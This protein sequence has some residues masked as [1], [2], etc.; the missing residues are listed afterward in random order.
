MFQKIAIAVLVLMV[1]TVAQS[2]M[3]PY[4][5][6]NNVKYD[7]FDWKTYKTAHFEIFFYP[8]SES[9]LQRV[10]S[11]AESA[12]DKVSADLQHDIEF[13]IPLITKIER[14]GIGK[15]VLRYH[16]AVVNINSKVCDLNI[17]STSTYQRLGYIERVARIR[18]VIQLP[19]EYAVVIN[20]NDE[21]S[22]I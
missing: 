21:S 3:V 4:Y 2:Q 13:K 7:S 11:M 10:A 18:E 5:G 20:L 22:R 8:E 9:H 12:Y 6:K 17:C 15:L 14:S 19:T 1:A 16:H